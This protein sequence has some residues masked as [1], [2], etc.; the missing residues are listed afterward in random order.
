ML[1]GRPVIRYINFRRSRTK[2]GQCSSRGSKHNGGSYYYSRGFAPPDGCPEGPGWLGL[3]VRRPLA[4]E[5]T[6]VPAFG[7]SV[8]AFYEALGTAGTFQVYQFM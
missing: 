2:R 1:S 3:R 8:E 5:I 7:L 4:H 6:R